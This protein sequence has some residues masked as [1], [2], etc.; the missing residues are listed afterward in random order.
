L[1][2]MTTSCNGIK[3][4]CDRKSIIKMLQWKRAICL[5]GLPSFIFWRLHLW[6]NCHCLVSILKK[7]LYGSHSLYHRFINPTI[8]TG[9]DEREIPTTS[10]KWSRISSFSYSCVP[11]H[12][13]PLYGVPNVF[14]LFKRFMS[15]FLII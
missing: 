12:F 10:I 4:G 1:F 3:P 6:F 11:D 9:H 15:H 7:S 14:L 8:T 13:V 2:F 5:S